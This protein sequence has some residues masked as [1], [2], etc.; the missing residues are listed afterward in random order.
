LNE[1]LKNIQEC[2][3]KGVSALGDGHVDAFKTR[4]VLGLLAAIFVCELAGV[5]GS[6]FTTPAIPTWYASL[7]KPSFNPPSWVF[8]PVWLTLYALMGIALFMVWRKS[9]S[10]LGAGRA[11]GFFGVQLA[12]NVLWSIVFFGMQSPLFGFVV[13]VLLWVAVLA[14]M[15]LFYGISKGAG[16]LLLPYF[17]W[18]SFASV[19]N[20]SIL[21]LNP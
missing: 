2:D 6:I 12:L 16:L 3:V 11:L 13:I 17:L 18:G 9:F 10:R 8:A 20:L 1:T 19:L 21:I 4:D 14:T 5:V 15:V 7:K